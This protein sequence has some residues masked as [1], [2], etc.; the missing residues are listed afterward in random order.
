MTSHVGSRTLATH[1]LKLA[2]RRHWSQQD[3]HDWE[4]LGSGSFRV[5]L[6]HKTTKVV[7]KVERQTCSREWGGSKVEWQH[8]LVIGYGNRG[9]LKNARRLRK[10]TWE[11]CHIPATSGYTIDGRVVIAMEW[12]PYMMLDQMNEDEVELD[13]CIQAALRELRDKARLADLHGENIVVL[14]SKML[15]PIDLGSRL[16]SRGHAGALADFL[17]TSVES[18]GGY[19]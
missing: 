17:D 18:T 6:L 14:P 8:Y 19:I 16:L 12:M 2:K 11:Y 5:V 3:Q 13:P 9:E 4:K 7:Y 1:A 10:L 15:A